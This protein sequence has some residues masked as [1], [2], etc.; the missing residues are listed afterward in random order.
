MKKINVVV[1]ISWVAFSSCVRQV[2]LQSPFQATNQPYRAIPMVSDEKSSAF[3][4]S[5]SIAAGGANQNLR[6]GV[7]Q[8]EGSIHR[9]HTL[10]NFQFYYGVAG[11]AGNYHISGSNSYY[12]GPGTILNGS[13]GNRFTAGVGGFGGAGLVIPFATGSEWRVIGL[14]S[15]YY[16]EL[17]DYRNYRLKLPDSAATAVSRTNN[18][19]TIGLTTNVIK[20][21]RKSGNTFGYKFGFYVSTR[22]LKLLDDFNDRYLVPAFISNTLHLT[23]QRITGYVQLNAGS[24]AL[25][26]QTGF[27]VRLGR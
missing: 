16:H 12:A 27:N 3:Y 24:Y 4:A 13:S 23:R 1:L 15:S 5:G 19:H 2:Y 17:G 25:N 10:P 7:F 14:E 26:F 8:F 22:R 9:S 6:D 18:F 21:F 20:K 11:M